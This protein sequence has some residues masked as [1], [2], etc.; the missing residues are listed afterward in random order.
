[1]KALPVA[2]TLSAEMDKH[3]GLPLAGSDEKRKTQI[4]EPARVPGSALL[5][6]RSWRN[7]TARSV[8]GPR[9]KVR[10]FR[11]GLFSFFFSQKFHFSYFFRYLCMRKWLR[12]LSSSFPSFYSTSP[13][14]S[15]PSSSSS[16]AS[17][18]FSFNL[19]SYQF[20]CDGSEVF[21]HSTLVCVLGK[22]YQTSVITYLPLFTYFTSCHCSRL[23]HPH[24]PR[25]FVSTCFTVLL[26]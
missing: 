10:H 6:L 26:F 4:V 15:S 9:P 3:A 23:P 14:S 13:P 5:K 18:S 8:R 12:L 19:L 20:H 16:S 22:T 21:S 24:S 1:M 7:W 17:Y 2:A 11:A 25:F